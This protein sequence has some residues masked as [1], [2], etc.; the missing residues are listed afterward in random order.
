MFVEAGKS[1][2]APNILRMCAGTSESMASAKRVIFCEGK[3]RFFLKK[4]RFFLSEQTIAQNLC[5]LRGTL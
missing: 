3:A 2:T 5:S 4:A 1:D